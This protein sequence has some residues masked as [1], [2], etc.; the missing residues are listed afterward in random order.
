MS[1]RLS[2]GGHDR[3]A[4]DRAGAQTS[5]WLWVALGVLLI[6]RLLW[7]A[8]MPL[9][10]SSEARYADIGRRMLALDDWITPWFDDGVP[11]WGKPPLHTWMTAAGLG[12]FG[13]NGLGARLPHWLAGM[14]VALVVWDWQR[15]DHGS[16]R[17]QWTVA[18]LWA[19]AGFYIVAGA[20]LTDMA[21]LLGLVLAQ[22]GF[23]RGL[24]APDQQAQ[25]EGWLL[26]VGL[27]IGL[28]AKGPIALLLA[29]VPIAV[30]LV[31]TRAF[32]RTWHRLPWL[33]GTLCM[34]AIALP[35]Y[36]LAERKT[37][38]FLNYFLI[39]EHW[40]RFTVPGWT[41]DLYGSAHLEARGMVWL[42]LLQ[43][44]L[45]WTLLLPLLARGRRAYRRQTALQPPNRPTREGLYLWAWVLWPCLFFTGSRNIL[46]TYVLPALPALAMLAAAWLD[47]DTRHRRHERLLALGVLLTA[48]LLVGVSARLVID[49]RVK[50]ARDVIAAFE[51]RRQTSDELL[52]VG[53]RQFSVAF[54]G[55]GRYQPLPDFEALAKRLD[56]ASRPH[57]G[58]RFVA[59]RRWVGAQA[60]PALQ[61]R[62]QQ[63][64][65][66]QGYVL[67]EVV[68]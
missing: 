12:V 4:P 48:T 19:S 31:A 61:E 23:W 58:R 8:F 30:W 52:F 54:Y 25:R 33:R 13:L 47:H 3:A 68:R 53:G 28:L 11:F 38:G 59:L 63:V 17:A 1:N 22:R 60:P 15:R 27:A 44:C 57:G 43:A 36:M 14:L 49:E 62:L 37:P 66:Y 5:T 18:L 67:L 32:K 7:M 9:A 65:V 6:V 2:P 34:L 45:P 40:R 41:G 21:L 46:W 20:V 55:Q 39:G 50:S 42:F 24:H 64:G 35:W 10:D 29:G 56:A 16:A 51:D 26:F